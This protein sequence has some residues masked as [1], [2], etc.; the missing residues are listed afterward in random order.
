MR[1]LFVFCVLL[2]SVVMWQSLSLRHFAEW[3]SRAAERSSD[4]EILIGVCW[5]FEINKDGME[6]GIVLALDEINARRIRG[7]RFRLVWR[8][9]HLNI[10]RTR[11]IA[12]EFSRTPGMV[13]TIGYY[14]SSSAVRASAIFEESQ[15]LHITIGSNNTY[16]T[17]RDF[18]YLIRTVL[19]CIRIGPKLARMCLDRGY[20]KVAIVFEDSPF[21]E[22]L[23]YHFEVVLDSK[24]AQTVYKGS[25]V[26]GMVDFREMVDELKA[27][28]A[29]LILFA[30]IEAEG[31]A[32]IRAAR[33]M[34]LDTPI[35][36]SFDDLPEMHRV[37]EEALEGVMFYSLY[38]VNSGTPENRAFVT[39][40]RKRF[41]HLPGVYAAQAYDALN[42]LAA[43]FE[44]T[45][46]T[47]PLDLSYAIR[48]RE[49]WEGANGTYAFESSGEL[50]DKDLFLMAYR[51]GEAQLIG[52]S[53]AMS[54]DDPEQDLV[55]SSQIRPR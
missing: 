55:R 24:D 14:D 16:M 15:L 44:M 52:V 29:E 38:N 22:D 31:A 34:G 40:F 50:M 51:D 17:H 30:G 13:A 53:E 23:A 41:G 37:P 32:F 33:A 28:Q 43:A 2:A 7:K 12:L 21:G 11:D 27:V 45:G 35:L 36:G 46:S 48:F 42:I 10:E 4:D 18:R 54:A 6:E 19:P 3:R 47:N 49:P 9:D 39:K 1:K 8:D 20:R 5:P 26:R 25:Y